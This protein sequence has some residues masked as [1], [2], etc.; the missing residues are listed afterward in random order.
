VVPFL[1][2]DVLEFNRDVYY[3]IYTLFVALLCVG[4]VRGSGVGVPMLLSRNWR[5]GVFLGAAFAGLLMLIV[6]RT[7]EATS[8]PNGVAYA[9]AILWRGVVYGVADGVLLSAF[10]ILLVFTALSP[11]RWRTRAAVAALALGV[12]LLFTAVY[13]L[14][15]P[16]FRGEKLRKPLAGGFVWSAPTLL[17]M[18]P[19]GTPI[20]HAG[21][22]VSAVVHSYDTDTFLPPHSAADANARPDLQRILDE[23][24]T[25]PQRLAPGATAYVTWPGGQWSGAAGVANVESGARMQPDARM[26]LESVS[27]IWTATLVMQLVAER[28][29]QLADTVERWLPAVFPFGD[30]IT[31]Q[32]L[33][34]HT[35]GMFD[36]N[37]AYQFPELTLQRVR[38]PA[39]RREFL[40]LAKRYQA[41]RR[42]TV[43]PMFLIRLAASQPL[44]FE[45]GQGYHY[46]NIGFT[47][48]GLVASR[49][50]RKPIAQMFAERI[51][52]PLGL[53]DT[54]YDPQGPIRGP[55]ARGYSMRP[56]GS[57]IDLTDAHAGKAADGGIV[58]TARETAAFLTE[59]MQGRFLP[60]RALRSMQAYAFWNGGSLTRCGLV[61]YGHGGAG[62]GFK[63]EVLASG[64][65]GWVAV[66][67]LNGRNANTDTRAPAVA[68]RL[69]CA[70]RNP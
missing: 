25:G 22:H 12:S 29:L 51:F 54:A 44:Y 9:A 36:D 16:D 41:N 62:G 53:A 52:R 8:H 43:S 60:R 27:K 40:A 18:S 34:T 19:L 4:W 23:I 67:F 45:P 33:L 57:L 30:R 64:D 17:T 21:L 59:L 15:Y 70:G 48:L 24:T 50:T 11:R 32:Q 1:F 63:T 66:L 68:Q 38:D 14:G 55:H 46:S 2:A 6:V 37:D 5:W 39:L 47:T 7:D 31:I 10:P 49:V 26:R 3:G 69:F 56:G 58:S 65:G 13:H 28:K 42:L 20:A 61:V 35:S